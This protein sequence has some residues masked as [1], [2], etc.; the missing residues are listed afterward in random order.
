MMFNKVSGKGG[1]RT[2]SLDCKGLGAFEKVQLQA[3][4]P[5]LSVRRHQVSWKR[6]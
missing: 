4:P 1:S 2:F 6:A 5:D 3:A